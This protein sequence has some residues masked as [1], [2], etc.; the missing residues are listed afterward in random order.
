[1][2]AKVF[3]ARNIDI[4]TDFANVYFVND[5]SKPF[6]LKYFIHSFYFKM[7]LNV[8]NLYHFWSQMQF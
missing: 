8:L 6:L 4:E 1:M 7:S 2:S 3:K 5:I